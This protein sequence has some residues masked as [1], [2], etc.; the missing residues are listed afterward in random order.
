MKFDKAFEEDILA[1]CLR[2]T[3]Y[4]K[5]A[6]RICDGHHF[7]SPQ[8]AWV[9]K[10]I[11]DIWDKYRERATGRLIVN[12]AKADFESDEERAAI[13]EL[14]KKV[15][16]RKPRAAKAKLA[17][18]EMF[19]KSVNAQVAIE[20]GARA[21]EKGDVD[22]VYTAL[23]KCVRHEVTQ[24]TYTHGMWIEQFEQRQADRKFRKEHPDAFPRIPTGF[25]QLDRLLDGGGQPGEVGLVMGTT[26][27]G[28]SIC[29]TNM[30]FSA[31]RTG[32]PA[33]YISMEMPERQI[34]MRQDA[35]WLKIAY[36]KFK[37]YD[38]KPSELNA[39][40]RRLEKAKK[41]FANK[42]HIIEVP[43]RRC[44]IGKI[45]SMLDDLQ[46]DFDFRPKVLFIDS[47]DHMNASSGMARESFRLQ[48]ASVY[49]DLATLADE[50]GMLVWTTCHAG[51]EYK[52]KIADV[53][54]ASES[55]D[56]AR[57]ADIGFSINEPVKEKRSTH[58][59]SDEDDD[60]SVEIKPKAATTGRPM[61]L[62]LSKYRDGKGQITIPIDADFHRMYMTEVDESTPGFR[63]EAEQKAS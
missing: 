22:A 14:V 38:W 6:A 63:V 28:K 9:W 59:S 3:K 51:R 52:D 39:I 13:I 4:L 23:R 58:I 46:D 19:V 2:D 8:Y 33:L 42:L 40:R 5:T 34:S 35:R 47:A 20:E 17:E 45:R 26:G 25:K 12:R 43:L 37:N 1:S 49:W 62:K 32:F 15:V 54:A 36:N 11:K 55:Y 50:E 16:K 48:Q 60:E 30:C 10:C 53:E 56:K 7:H 57:I 44:D 61:I 18:L 27:K 29:L 41:Q 24:R 21:L 31:V